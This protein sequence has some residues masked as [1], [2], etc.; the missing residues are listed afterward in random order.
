M[1][2]RTDED[3]NNI[4]TIIKRSI[5][6]METVG[7]IPLKIIKLYWIN[8]DKEQLFPLIELSGE[9]ISSN[10]DYLKANKLTEYKLG[11]LMEELYKKYPDLKDKFKNGKSW[12]DSYQKQL[13]NKMPNFII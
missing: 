2:Q 5:Y 3:L 7:G 11:K 8:D 6:S 9:H 10:E 13:M 12:Y 1:K 4:I